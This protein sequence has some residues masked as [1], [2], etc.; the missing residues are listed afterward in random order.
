MKIIFV[1]AFGEKSTNVAQARG[2]EENGC[3]VTNFPY[4]DFRNK[5]EEI[6]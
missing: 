4:R 5:D 6:Q 1:G 3:E 2:F